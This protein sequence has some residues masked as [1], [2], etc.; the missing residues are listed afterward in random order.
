MSIQLLC[1]NGHALQVREAYAG[2]TGVCPLC[3]ARVQIPKSVHSEVT[4]EA[5]LGFLGPPRRSYA[6]AV[7]GVVAATETRSE[8]SPSP[9]KKSCDKCNREILAATHIC[10]YCHTY[11]AG[12]ADF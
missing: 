8:V 1:P 9:P 5:I 7:S 4:E 3:R 6:P 12:L 10:P 11:I 2:K